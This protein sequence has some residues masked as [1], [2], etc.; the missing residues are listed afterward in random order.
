[1]LRGLKQTLCKPRPRGPT[2]TETELCLSVSWGGAGQ[3][4]P[5][6]GQGLWAQH[7]WV[8]HKPSYRR[9]PS[10]LPQELPEI[11]QDWGKSLSEGTNKI[12][13][14]PGPRRKEPWPHK[15]LTQ[16]CPWVSQILWWRRGL[17]MACRRVRGTEGSR[18]CMAAFEGGR[19]S[20]HYL[21]HSLAS[22]QTRR[23]HSP[24]HQQKIE[25][26][27]YWAWPGS[28][29]KDPVAPSVSLSHQEASIRLLIL[30]IRRQTECKPQSQ[31]TKQTNHMDQ[32]LV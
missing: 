31:K 16:T 20:L 1:M 6:T 15:R 29:E 24:D 21:H 25:S 13:C 32:S 4:W 26:K 7:T 28:S 19:H 5:A 2:E 18:A 8:W 3:Q 12:L 11:M 23:E 30:S 14:A 10:T 9:S 17:A 27:I 22:G